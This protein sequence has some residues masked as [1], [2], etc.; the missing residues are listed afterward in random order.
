MADKAQS[1]LF[2]NAR[3][4]WGTVTLG[5]IAVN[6]AETSD[7][8]CLCLIGGGEHIFVGPVDSSRSTELTSL[9]CYYHVDCDLKFS[10]SKGEFRISY[11]PT[12][13][14]EES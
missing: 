6:R 12:R 13:E 3:P 11:C 2:G 9:I 14:L 4:R 1:D 8:R 10:S 5:R 7:K